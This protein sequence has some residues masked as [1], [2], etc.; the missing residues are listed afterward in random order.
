MY[1]LFEN[2]LLTFSDR[3]VFFKRRIRCLP[4][5]IFFGR[6]GSI[7]F[8]GVNMTE[9]WVRGATDVRGT[10]RFSERTPRILNRNIVVSKGLLIN[11][12]TTKWKLL[13]KGIDSLKMCP[14]SY[15]VWS[16]VKMYGSGFVHY[17]HMQLLIY[18]HNIQWSPFVIGQHN[19]L[20]P[21]PHWA[22]LWLITSN[23]GIAFSIETNKSNTK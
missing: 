1:T 2:H 20:L 10:Q 15:R 9:S 14:R 4:L 22:L 23:F 17:Q 19:E 6:L 11:G 5:I 21:F 12:E 16:R 7:F 3:V 13:C 8:F 18:R